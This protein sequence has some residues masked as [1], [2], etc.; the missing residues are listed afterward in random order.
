MK[1]KFIYILLSC[2]LAQGFTACENV[3][4]G[5]TN[6]NVN[7][8]DKVYPAGL[9]SGAMMSFATTTGRSNL[10]VPT[11]LVQWQSQVTYTDEMLYAQSPY[12]WASYYNNMLLN[13]DQVIEYNKDEKNHTTELLA[14]GD[15]QNQI[16]VAMIM[17]SIIIKRVTDTWGAVPYSQAL[18]GLDNLTPAYDKQED[19]YKTLIADLK[20]GRDMINTSKSAPIGDLIYKGNLNSWKKLA[21][22]VLLQSTL[23]LSKVYPGASGFAATEFTAALNDP[24]GVIDEVAEEAWFEYERI[25]TGDY[26]NP[27]SLNRARDYFL[28]AEFVDAMKGKTGPE[29]YNPT[30]NGTF[31]GRLAGYATSTTRD[32][33]PYGFAD[34]SGRG[35]NQVSLNYFWDPTAPLPLMTAS[36]TYLNRAEAAA[37]GWTTEDAKEMLE[38]GI[39]MS[40]NTLEEHLLPKAR[41]ISAAEIAKIS[42]ISEQGDAYADARLNDIAIAEGGILQ[43]IG[44]EKWKSLFPQGFDAW[45]EWRRTGYPVLTPATDAV[46]SGQ[47]PT[48]YIY[49]VEEAA[50]NG[51][52]NTQAVQNLAPSEDIN[53]AKVWWDR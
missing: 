5:D 38:K 44:E 6:E 24:N 25:A 27:Y 15:P 32:G 19:I 41:T 12:S 11:L 18:K 9:M 8:P 33:V 42:G 1:K 50:V 36:Y 46:N 16:G 7:G 40:F 30:S 34:G 22:S 17:K 14:Q 35:K 43:V 20:A 21:N 37:L 10:L 52:N 2:M 53:T 26:S 13:L 45:S 4:F 31:D 28:S 39:E 48:R 51:T 29:S 47:I 49:P 3:D 23:Q